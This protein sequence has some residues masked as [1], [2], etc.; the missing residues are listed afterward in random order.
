M[1][2]ACWHS[3]HAENNA[4]NNNDGRI[5]PFIKIIILK[6]NYLYSKFFVIAIAIADM[7]TDKSGML[8]IKFLDIYMAIFKKIIDFII[9]PSC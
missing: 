5:L 9:R 2:N 6:K 7:N 1:P 8:F 3:M 4:E